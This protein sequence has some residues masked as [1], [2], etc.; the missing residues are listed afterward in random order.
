MRN[1]YRNNRIIFFPGF[2]ISVIGSAVFSFVTGFYLLETT[3]K[4]S[5]YAMNLFLF[6]IPLIIFGPL[7]GGFA[8]K[9][10]KKKLIIIGDLLN[11]ILMLG[12]FFLW[13]KFDK[14]TLIYVGTFFSSLFSNLVSVSFSSGVPRFFGKDWIVQ[15]NSL[16]QIINSISRILGPFLGGVIYGYGNIKLFILVNGISFFISAS[17]E[18]FLKID[19]DKESLTHKTIGIKEGIRYIFENLELKD[20]LIKFCL[21][22]FAAIVAIIIP[23]PYIVSKI[24]QLNSKA[25]GLIQGTLP[26]GAILGAIL[27]NK[28][29]FSL[30]KKVF[31]GIFS[32]FFTTC[33]ILFLPYLTHIDISTGKSI[34]ILSMFISGLA[35]GILD[36]TALT[37]FQK[38]VPE[39]IRGKIMGLVTG[40][41]KLI[42]P[43]A[44]FISGKLT[45]LYSPFASIFLGGGIIFITLIS[46]IFRI[47]EGFD[48]SNKTFSS[49][50]FENN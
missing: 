6:T 47:N 4:V 8:D 31:I 37:Y 41:V 26:V 2:M 11:T 32:L 21:I 46:S 16:S 49:E 3:E 43:L 48:K 15:A 14:M 20:F 27:V 35:F 22:N 24:F 29:R 12:I 9:Y 1:H 33:F 7:L 50:N 39:K 17:I 23:V 25:L 36:V 30:N 40:I 42:M 28:K 38:N 45:D 34:L 18:L 5:S 13:D 10:S 44:F 19:T